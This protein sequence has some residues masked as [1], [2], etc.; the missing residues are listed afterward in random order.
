MHVMPEVEGARLPTSR[1]PLLM[2]RSSLHHQ[3]MATAHAPPI[4]WEGIALS[5]SLFSVTYTDICLYFF[6]LYLIQ[7]WASLLSPPRAEASD[8]DREKS[9]AARSTCGSSAGQWRQSTPPSRPPTTPASQ[10]NEVQGESE[11]GG[12]SN[13]FESLD[14]GTTDRDLDGPDSARSNCSTSRGETF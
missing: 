13:Y 7:P 14:T 5:L 8:S 3:E 4:S 11:G 6:L 12:D 2:S 10:C 1:G 9:G